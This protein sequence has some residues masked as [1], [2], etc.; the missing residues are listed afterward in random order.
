MVFKDYLFSRSCT[1]SAHGDSRVHPGTR[2]IV[3]YASTDIPYIPL[4][5]VVCIRISKGVLLNIEF[6]VS[7]FSF[8]V[9]QSTVQLT[10]A[11][12]S[13]QHSLRNAIQLYFAKLRETRLVDCP[14][15][16]V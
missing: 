7:S 1:N 13:R 2:S 10:Y 3:Q 4:S 8:R 5:L 11:P 9:E 14:Y 12:K 15:D 16:I 6:R